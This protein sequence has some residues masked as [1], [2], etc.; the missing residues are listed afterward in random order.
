[1]NSVYM[2]YFERDKHNKHS[3]AGWRPA[4]ITQN[5][6]GNRYSPI[7]HA[8]PLT[9]AEHN[10]AYMPTHVFLDA[11][12]CGLAK[13]SI[14]L[15]EQEQLRSKDDIGE[16]ITTLPREY[17]VKIAEACTEET[18]L[19]IHMDNESIIAMV[20]RLRK[21]YINVEERVLATA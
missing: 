6:I 19:L 21:K 16:Y 5:D 18:P 10:K 1:M 2:V 4:I 7:I 11:K 9:G 20:E 17:I 14:A 3:Q 15:C 8:V 13:D 12:K